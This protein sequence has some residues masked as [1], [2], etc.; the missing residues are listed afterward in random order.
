M[1]L[2]AVFA[3]LDR[4]GFVHHRALNSPQA[5]RDAVAL[6]SRT[7]V[8]HVLEG[9]LCWHALGG[10]RLYYFRHPKWLLDTLPPAE[11]ERSRAEGRLV[12]LEDVLAERA[13]G[14][15]FIIELKVGVGDRA[16]VL[17]DVTGLLREA[18]P[19]R[20]WFDGFSLR[21]LAAVKRAEPTAATSLHTKLVWGGWVL[22]SAPEVPP[23][24]LHHLAA[25]PYVDAVTL[26]W[27]TS[28]SR[29]LG[30]GIDDACRSV[31]ASGKALILGGLTSPQSF[32]EARASMAR[33]GYAK[34]P[35]AELPLFPES[36]P[37]T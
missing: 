1:N 4:F 16:A 17:R 23:L 35:L 26:T 14:L 10:R 6:A 8:C 21:L 7:D 30:G 15:R 11:L 37:R 29:L 18:H 13:E 9:D 28:P 24:S 31:R 19:G 3:G 12:M 32:A 27:K 25:L 34:F 5:F 33:A 2:P 36:E 22:R 20:H